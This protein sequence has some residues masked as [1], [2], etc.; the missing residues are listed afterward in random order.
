MAYQ[1]I[2]ILTAVNSSEASSTPKHGNMIIANS[3]NVANLATATMLT[4]EEG[5][6]SMSSTTTFKEKYV[7]SDP[8]NSKPLV[9]FSIDI[10]HCAPWLQLTILIS[11]LILFMC[12]YGYYQ[13]LVIYGWFERRLSIFSTFLHFLGCSV[14]AQIQRNLSSTSGQQ[15]LPLY[16]NGPHNQRSS[17]FYLSMGTATPRLAFLYYLSLVLLKT[18]SQGLSNM[19][20]S[21]INYP[22]KVLFKSANPIITMMIGVCYLRKTYPLRDYFVVV[23][24]VLGLYIFITG[25]AKSSPQSTSLGIFYVV[26][27]M[28]GSAGVP[29]IQEYCIQTYNASIED[30]IYFSFLG[31]ALVSLLLSILL[32]EF[33]SGLLFLLQQSSLH[34]W[35]I[36]TA[37]CTFGFCGANFSTAITAQ[38]GALIN[39]MSNTFRK[40][41]TLGVSFAMFP[42]RNVLT[43][44][45]VIGSIVFF[46]GLLVKILQKDS[47]AKQHHQQSNHVM[48]SSYE[49]SGSTVVGAAKR[50]ASFLVQKW[51]DLVTPSSA[52]APPPSAAVSSSGQ[53]TYD[54]LVNNN[55]D[56]EDVAPSRSGGNQS[57]TGE[58]YSRN[59]PYHLSS[60]HQ[61]TSSVS[62]PRPATI[63]MPQP[64]TPSANRTPFREFPREEDAFVNGSHLRNNVLPSPLVLESDYGSESNMAALAEAMFGNEVIV[65]NNQ[66]NYHGG[67]LRSSSN[68]IGNLLS[69]PRKRTPTHF[70]ETQL[71]A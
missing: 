57:K 16:S 36:F 63:Y 42:E 50:S 56:Y 27:S 61:T 10:S 1:R 44:Q 14:F 4:A 62:Q 25:D 7:I 68:G 70:L 35:F 69:P 17:P 28:L 59:P 33:G 3:T 37:F 8:N 11:G 5:D 18:A 38:Y 66:H 29:M 67:A 22:A 45:K 32:G 65:P 26:L 49:G 64:V 13:E 47:F 21:Q 23:L 30:L 43:V 2:S 12:L 9:L 60:N 71:N 20:M 54:A 40:A 46:C 52:L 19:S 48:S 39:G 51:N 55:V 58:G 15:H 31:S 24:L 34:N 41:V 6:D 53:V